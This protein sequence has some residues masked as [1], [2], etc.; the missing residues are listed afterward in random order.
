MSIPIRLNTRRPGEPGTC[1]A[2]PPGMTDHTT[3]QGS[4][5]GNGQGRGSTGRDGG[6]VER[7]G[8]MIETADELCGDGELRREPLVERAEAQ[9]V[10]RGLAERAYDLA[11][12]EKLPPAYGMAITAAG[13][14]VQPLE[15]P[16]PDVGETSSGEPSW[17]DKPPAPGEADLERRL[18]QTFRR[19]RSFVDDAPS[20]QAAFSAFAREPD[21]ERYDY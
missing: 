3:D 21:L 12:E 8:R 6:L 10:D 11:M 20:P 14:S 5:P 15:S 7:L 9:G 2:P 4:T 18:R 13:V 16:R 17:V 1:L 19:L